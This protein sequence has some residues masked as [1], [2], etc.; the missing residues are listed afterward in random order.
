VAKKVRH[1]EHENHERWLVSYADFITLLFA[2]FVVM[3]SISSVNEGKFRTVSES[4]Q[5]ALRPV[6]SQPAGRAHFDVGDFKSSL[7]P[8]LGR[9]VQFVRQMQEVVSRFNPEHF[10]NKLT[11]TQ[12]DHGIVI[13]IADNLMFESGRAVIRPEAL[14]VLEGLAEVLR[15]HISSV[16][17]V[18]VQGHTDNVPIRSAVFPSNW[19]LSAV[20]A[21]IVTRV[22]TE[23]YHV[24]PERVSAAGFA[25]FKPMTDNLTPEERAKNRRVELLVLMNDQESYHQSS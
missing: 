16:K 15:D 21:V 1:E 24:P 10:Q 11:V 13:T 19:E 8:T 23:L 2:F 25:E 18:R 17:E 9:R 3:Y 22:L 6:V 20:R 12:N 5:A 7:V 14:P 4:I